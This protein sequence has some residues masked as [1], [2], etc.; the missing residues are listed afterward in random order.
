MTTTERSLDRIEDIID[1]YV[2]LGL[3]DILRPLSPYGFAVKTKQI[4]K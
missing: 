4:Q 3:M 1:E 2:G